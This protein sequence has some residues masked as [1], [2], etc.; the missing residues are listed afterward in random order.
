MSL[1]FIE[2]VHKIVYHQLEEMVR[3][4]DERM[5]LKLY[6]IVLQEDCSPLATARIKRVLTGQRDE[7]TQVILEKLKGPDEALNKLGL[8]GQPWDTVE[9]LDRHIREMVRDREPSAGTSSE[10]SLEDSAGEEF[11]DNAESTTPLVTQVHSTSSIIYP[12]QLNLALKGKQFQLIYILSIDYAG[13]QVRRVFYEVPNLSF[14]RMTLD[15]YFIDYYKMDVDYRL[16]EELESKY[17]EN[18]IGF[19]QRMARM[20]LGK[21]QQY[22]TDGGEESI[23]EIHGRVLEPNHQYYI[24]M[25]MEKIEGIATR[26]YEGESPFGCMLL[27]SPKL[28]SERTGLVKYAIQFEG[29]EGISLEDGRRIRKLLEMT[30]NESDLFL[31]ADEHIIYGIGEVDWSLLGMDHVFKLEF[32]GLSRYD[33]MLITMREE[34]ATDK[35]VE[36]NE[37]KKIFKM[38][39][40]LRIISDKILG[41][42][43]KNPEISQERFDL[44]L[45][46]RITVATFTKDTSILE[47]NLDKLGKMIKEATRQQ[48]GTMVVI[49]KPETAKSEVQR[50]QKQS[51]P[52]LKTSI[53]PAFIK[54]LTA[55]D[56]ALYC[57]TEADCHAIGVILDGLAQKNLG[58]A[59]R[60][61]RFNSAYRYLEKL[62]LDQTA[63]VIAIIS[64]D[65][66]VN[67]IPEPITERTVRQMVKEYVDYIKETE[68]G[69]TAETK[70]NA[71]EERLE[72][73]GRTVYIDDDYYF[74]LGDTW[75]EHEDYLKSSEHYRRGILQSSDL[76]IAYHRKLAKSDFRYSS[77]LEQTE[78]TLVLQK[79]LDTATYIIAN[80]D[81]EVTAEDYN[82]RGIA[83]HNLGKSCKDSKQKK[84]ILR[85]RWRTLTN[86]S[87]E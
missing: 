8:S 57:D 7:E 79:L 22:I 17:K 62:R 41:V 83:Q 30:N 5:E 69:K 80:G 1:E 77:E 51:T 67:L 60:G 18:E 86:Q 58:D 87:A 15:Y 75:F 68:N 81:T 23:Q 59:S 54:Y 28:L 4:L 38:T 32:K 20:F 39:T 33:L 56:G 10:H 37:D 34:G 44:D 73:A 11:M 53:N 31:I 47:H 66:M 65:G 82:L 42:S 76:H 35:R 36:T 55:I 24:N 2:N 3:R 21:V 14:L 74:L 25:L 84:S 40:N 61:A 16:G 48:S 6:A 46:K 85:K 13:P 19:L 12:N 45:F 63:C 27:M 26:T 50:L 29:E 64:E 78:K 52:I 70:V 9:R 43:F 49:T 72:Q 71:Y